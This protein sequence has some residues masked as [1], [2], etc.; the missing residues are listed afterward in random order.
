MREEYNLHTHMLLNR[1]KPPQIL[2]YNSYKLYGQKIIKKRAHFVSPV[3][4]TMHYTM[5][6]EHAKGDARLPHLAYP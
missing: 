1:P 3:A 6:L 5:L 4:L 2:P